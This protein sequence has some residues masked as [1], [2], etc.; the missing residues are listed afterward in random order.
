MDLYNNTTF[1]SDAKTAAKADLRII[2][3]KIY[4]NLSNDN[5]DNYTQIHLESEA[6]DIEDI[7]AARFTI[8]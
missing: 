4:S 2:L 3:K 7:F 5:L 1:P 8:D 6:E